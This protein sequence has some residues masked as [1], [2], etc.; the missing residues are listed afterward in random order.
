MC[1]PVIP[2]AVTWS[3]RAQSEVVF[4]DED[5]YREHSVVAHFTSSV[6][7][8]N[9]DL[10]RVVTGSLWGLGEH[11]VGLRLVHVVLFD[12]EEVGGS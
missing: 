11:Q 7:S 1:N 8:R 12:G 5:R 6:I 4:G 9:V 10:N 2:L 3:H